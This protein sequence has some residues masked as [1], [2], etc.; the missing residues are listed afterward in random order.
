LGSSARDP[1]EPNETTSGHSFRIDGVAGSSVLREQAPT[2]GIRPITSAHGA[3]FDLTLGV[4]SHVPHWA[5]DGGQPWAYEPYVREMEVWAKL[6]ARVHVC[7][8]VAEWPLR[9]DEAPYGT[10][11]VR[12]LPVR[13][14]NWPGRR[15][16]ALRLWQ[17][18]ALRR[19]LDRLF[20]GSDLVLLRSPAT[21]SMVARAM[22]QSRGLATITKY[23]GRFRRFPGE[24]PETR[25]ERIQIAR[26]PGPALVYGETRTPH[27]ISFI[28]A[29]M[30][31][32]ELA[33]ARA[34]ARRRLWEPPWRILCVGR[35]SPEKGFDLAL[36]GLAELR[37]ARGEL[38]WELTVVGG[39][40][41]A[42]RLKHLAEQLGIAGRVSFPGALPFER[43]REHFA[44]A[45]VVVMPGV[46]E[47]WP[48]TI[49]EAWA[50]GAVPA[51]AAAGL[52]PEIVGDAG[53]VFDPSPAGLANALAGALS[54]PPALR[55]LGAQGSERCESLSLETF[56][57]RLERVLVEHC[58]L[59]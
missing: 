39:G 28:P 2:D 26:G 12:W 36:R 45:H 9:G 6:F 56:Q 41:E 16:H 37:R 52:A 17:L 22:A 47:G 38:E 48:K 51:A 23:A 29:L 58:R 44:A 11:N 7:A 25:L 57:D 31:N 1:G 13:F 14:S 35:L 32:A 10:T 40:S 53:L 4:V 24:H 46:Q 27:L 3:R 15:R 42:A 34:L 49:A 33:E 54:D 20:E 21:I 5:R 50:Y 8:P 43:V 18:R 55:A 59:A 30:S 19:S